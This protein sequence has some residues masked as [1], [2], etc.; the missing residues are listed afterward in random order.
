M[1]SRPGDVAPDFSTPTTGV[2]ID[3]RRWPGNSRGGFTLIEL[4]VVI[5]II[6]ILAALLLPVLSKAKI[7]AQGIQCMSNTR[8][9]T[10][11]WLMYTQNNSDSLPAADGAVLGAPEWD[12]GGFMDFAANNPVNYDITVNLTR[13]PLWKYCSS[14]AGIWKC[15]A[16]RSTVLKGAT[17]VPRVRSVTMNCFMGGEDGS[18]AF[19]GVMA[20][21]AKFRTFTKLTGIPT[22]DTYY[23]FLDE[24]EDSINNGWFGVSMAGIPYT[25][26][27]ANPGLYAFFDFPAYY[28]NNAAGFSFADG[29][30]EIQKWGDGRTMPPVRDVTLVNVNGTPSPGNRDIE[31]LGAHASVPK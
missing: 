13:S 11:A 1:P 4:L 25:G 23:V 29:H 20:S 28:H 31:W 9:L 3:F 16:D 5:A 24:N 21:N 7:Q 6:A 10:L 18:A 8:Q 27:A 19:S 17:R 2:S 26:A 15:P 12:G 30:S 22:A 14:S